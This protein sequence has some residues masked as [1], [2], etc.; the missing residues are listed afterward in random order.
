MAAES[1]P[2]RPSR[3]RRP[4]EAAILGGER[5]AVRTHDVAR[6]TP[7]L[8]L[9]RAAISQPC[10]AKVLQAPYEV[11]SESIVTR[12]A[13]M[14]CW[15]TRWVNS[16][17]AGRKPARCVRIEGGP[18]VDLTLLVFARAKMVSKGLL[19][20]RALGPDN[21]ELPGTTATF[22]PVSATGTEIPP[23]WNDTS[24]PWWD[25]VR[26]ARGYFT[27]A[28]K[29]AAGWGEFVVH[30]KLPKPALRVDIGVAPLPVAI[31]DFG[32]D[33]PSFVLAVS[34]G[35]SER[36]VVRAG[37]DGTES[38]DD[39]DGLVVSL[40]DAEHALLKPNGEYRVVVHYK[41]ELGQKPVEPEEGQDP[42]EIVSLRTVSSTDAGVGPAVRT[43]FTDA[44]APR[45]LDPW[46]LAEFPPSGELYHFTDDPVVVVFATNDVLQ[47]FGAYSRQLRAIACRVLPRLRG[48]R[49]TITQFLVATRYEPLI[50]DL[51]R[52]GHG[53]P[54]RR[55][56]CADFN[57]DSDRHGRVTLPFALDPLTNTSSISTADARRRAGRPPLLP[58]D[59][60]IARCIGS[61]SPL[62]TIVAGRSLPGPCASRS[63]CRTVP[64]PAA[65]AGLGDEVTDDAFDTALVEA[66]LEVRQRPEHPR[67]VILWTADAVAQPFAVLIETPEPAWR[68][69]L[70]PEPEYDA[71]TGIY[72][73]RWLLQRR[74][75]LM[76]DELVR[77]T[78]ELVIHGGDF[79]QR[80]TGIKAT[81]GKSLVELRDLYLGPKQ[82]PPPP[83]PP[84]PASLVL[85]IVHDVSGTRTLAVLQP[86]SRGKVVSLALVRKLHPLLDAT[87][88]DTPE[89]FCEVDLEAPPWEGGTP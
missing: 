3:D 9:P 48:H 86:G 83:L 77:T 43:F 40:G 87:T 46:I 31:H 69:R 65:L 29:G 18:V 76:V 82:V 12:Q 36:E 53:A 79:I 61:R 35:L 49:G 45:N 32:M 75:W 1:E 44:A 13:S 4:A 28:L 70:E 38:D 26:L 71:E 19:K 66:G 78:P 23:R 67:V 27:G 57:P 14:P 10:V 63:W 47:L 62:R 64:N 2:T 39:L 20:V 41:A 58:S 6:L 25:D 15:P 22:A 84:P 56:P 11:L 80:G 42:N 72:I 55:A 7:A 24:G 85:K 51:H 37:D 74:T 33:P 16:T 5:V 73:Q 30:V 60:G 8:D 81:V 21:T 50:D 17:I 89:L 52:G 59:M 68:T 88:T 54:A 34:E